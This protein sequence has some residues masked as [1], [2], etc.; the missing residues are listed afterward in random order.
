MF[1]AD[2]W[3]FY[4]ISR[5]R[6]HSDLFHLTSHMPQFQATTN[7]SWLM[8]RINMHKCR[9]WTREQCYCWVLLLH[10]KAKEQ[11]KDKIR[12]LPPTTVF[13]MRKD[14][15]YSIIDFFIQHENESSPSFEFEHT[16]LDK[17]GTKK[18]NR[19]IKLSQARGS[20]WPD[21]TCWIESTRRICN[22]LYTSSLFLMLTVHAP[23]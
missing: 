16:N 3:S 10:I 22:C 11:K 1:T 20:L 19:M 2:T 15:S 8:T 9:I 13:T 21:V 7:M 5:E 4:F 23:V 14:R 12:F 18:S 6:I 17:R